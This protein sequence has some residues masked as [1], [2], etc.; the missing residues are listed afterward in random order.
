MSSMQVSTMAILHSSIF[1][2]EFPREFNPSWTAVAK[3]WSQVP[4]EQRDQHFFASLD[5][6][7]GPT[8]FQRVR[9]V[10]R[11]ISLT[12]YNPRI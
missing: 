8:I 9:S 2:S 7:D 11:S 5:F 1:I 4:P 10:C 6:D 3:S 12:F